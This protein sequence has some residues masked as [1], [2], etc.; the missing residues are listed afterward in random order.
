MYCIGRSTVEAPLVSLG[1]Q[2][3]SRTSSRF[4]ALRRS[5]KKSSNQ[6]IWCCCATYCKLHLRPPEAHKS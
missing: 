2:G 5:V 3:S 4:L 6:V 1:L